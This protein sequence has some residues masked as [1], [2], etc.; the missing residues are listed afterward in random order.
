LKGRLVLTLSCPKHT[1]SVVEVLSWLQHLIRLIFRVRALWLLMLGLPLGALRIVYCSGGA[2]RVYAIDVGYAQLDWKIR[3]DS[4]VVVLERRNIRYLNRE[5][6]PEPI[7]LAVIDVSFISLT[8][9]IPTVLTFLD[10]NALI[11]ALLKPQFE[12]GKGQVGR[13]GVVRNE[14]QRILVKDRLLKFFQNL[15]LDLIGVIDSPV[16]GRKGNKELLIA[17]RKPL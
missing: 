12:V 10:K 1:M 17:L 11:V 2:L 8:V 4:R 3:T 15:G 13:G 6:I 9:V 14:N 7:E 5:A 16:L